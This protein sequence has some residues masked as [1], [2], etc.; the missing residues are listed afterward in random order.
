MNPNSIRNFTLP[1]GALTALENT[2]ILISV[3]YWLKLVEDCMWFYVAYIVA[4][5][6]A[7]SVIFAVAYAVAT[8]VAHDFLD[9][10]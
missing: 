8:A 2:Q 4:Y 6:V 10:E 7:Y 5:T 9:D 1:K 3:L